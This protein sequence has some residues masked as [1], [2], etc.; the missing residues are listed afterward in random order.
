MTAAWCRRAR[1]ALELRPELR[2]EHAADV[3][4]YDNPTDTSN[5]GRRNQLRLAA[6]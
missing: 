3:E 2:F 1:D 5:A 4:A 6:T